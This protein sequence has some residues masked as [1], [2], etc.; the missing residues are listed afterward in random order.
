MA[1]RIAVGRR[2]FAPSWTMTA[3]TVLLLA[4]FVSLGR[5]Q[6]GRAEQKEALAR[7]FAAGAVQAQPLAARGTATLPRYAVV[8]VTGEW[9]AARQF[10]LDNRTRD[11]R[12]GYE[13]LTP[14]RLAD[15]RW[16]LVN[17]GWVPFEGRRDRLPEVATGL[18]PGTV[19]LRGRLDE[20]PTAGLASGRAAPALEGAWPRVTSFPQ[21]AELAASLADSA[22]E[23]GAQAPRLEPRVLLLD[24]SAP[25]GYR[26]DWQPFVK[27]PEQNISY[28]VQWWSFGV[29]LLVLFV[30]MNL[31]RR[32]DA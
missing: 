8:S 9:D 1:L 5:W 12:A 10:L 11:G 2:V 29:L 28:A 4:V 27:G 25:A 13:V 24:A 23:G 26:R 19:T 31:K 18:A 30:K 21:T 6:W 3:L 22:A 15:G 14:L 20:L 32:D 7:G 17:R 16:L